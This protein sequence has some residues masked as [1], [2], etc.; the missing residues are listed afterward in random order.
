MK[1]TQR[2]CTLS[3]VTLSEV[4]TGIKLI[5]C[6]QTSLEQTYTN[7]GLEKTLVKSNTKP[8]QI[9]IGT[10]SFPR[11]NKTNQNEPIAKTKTGSKNDEYH[12]PASQSKEKQTTTIKRIV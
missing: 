2:K 6:N 10:N 8:I 5:W 1:V 11:L 4:H 12:S 9:E 3:K 7:L